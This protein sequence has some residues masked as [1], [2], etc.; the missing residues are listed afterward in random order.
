MQQ[1]NY[2]ATIT[3]DRTPQETFQAINDVSGWWSDDLD[4]RSE[5]AGDEFTVRFG[6]IHVSTQKLIE[7]IP[8]RKVVWLVTDSRLNFLNDK[9]EWTNTRILFDIVARQQQTE[10]RLTHIG[11][12]PEIECYGSCTRGWDYYFKG[13]L[14]KFLTEGKGTPGLM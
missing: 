11:L 3:V 14:Y 9:S 1:P 12:V 10:V 7:L 5:Q 2:Q 8:D 6:D 13:S 4:G